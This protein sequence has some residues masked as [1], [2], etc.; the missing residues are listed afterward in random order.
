VDGGRAGRRR[1]CA[2]G[3][4]SPN[5]RAAGSGGGA[6]R[7]DARGGLPHAWGDACPSGVRRRL[8]CRAAG[9]GGVGQVRGRC[10]HTPPCAPAAAPP[11]CVG[12]TP[13]AGAPT[14]WGRAV[15]AAAAS[16]PA[17]RPPLPPWSHSPAARGGCGAPD[18]GRAAH[19][20]RRHGRRGGRRS[21]V[22]RGDG[23]RGGERGA[24]GAPRAACGNCFLF[25]FFVQRRGAGAVLAVAGR[26]DNGGLPSARGRCRRRPRRAASAVRLWWAPRRGCL[27]S[28]HCWP[29]ARV[30]WARAGPTHPPAYLNRAH[31]R[32]RPCRTCA[33]PLATNQADTPH[34]GAAGVMIS[35]GIRILAD[36][37]RWGMETGPFP[38]HVESFFAPTPLNR[39]PRYNNRRTSCTEGFFRRRRRGEHAAAP[40]G[41]TRRGF[42]GD[43][44][45]LHHDAGRSCV[46]RR[47]AP[48][49]RRGIGTP[50][51]GVWVSTAPLPWVCGFPVVDTLARFQVNHVEL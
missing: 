22:G 19:A 1:C 5:G 39:R 20:P 43:C 51:D 32:Q 35:G 25:W 49:H 18:G 23:R 24:P 27:E 16:P 41:G 9:G 36:F 14:G 28:T 38:K 15:A 33:T 2:G 47:D 7:R 46:Q 34:A 26:R 17:V 12:G 31:E 37:P 44:G 30:A 48:A 45:R 11:R 10:G 50:R 13:R 40:V 42:V 3:G 4:P 21:H 8:W 29:V 6:P